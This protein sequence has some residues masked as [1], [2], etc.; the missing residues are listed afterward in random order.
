[1]FTISQRLGCRAKEWVELLRSPTDR[2]DCN[3]S[4]AALDHHPG[5][6]HEPFSDGRVESCAKIPPHE[7]RLEVLQLRPTPLAGRLDTLRRMFL[8]M[9]TTATTPNALARQFN[10]E[11]VPHYGP[12]WT[13]SI[14]RQ[15]LQNPV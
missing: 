13:D 12:R 2:V 3:D 9:D 6:H 4:E 5:I 11:G 1:M 10:E 8:L 15:L 14:I 7:V